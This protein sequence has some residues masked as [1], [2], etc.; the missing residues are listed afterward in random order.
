MM[1]LRIS[2]ISVLLFASLMTSPAG[3]LESGTVFSVLPGA[4]Y[5][6]VYVNLPQDLG[7][8]AV[9]QISE[10]VIESN[11]NS[12]P[13]VDTTYS[14]VVIEPGVQNKNPVCFYYSSKEEGDFSFYSIKLSSLGLG[15]SNSISGG[16]CVSNYSD[17]DM[18]IDASNN[19][20]ICGL[21][22]ENA[23]IVDLSFGEDKTQARPGEV[24]SKTLYITSY[25]NL[26]IRLSIATNLQNDFG[27][28]AVTTSPSKPMTSRTFKIKAPDQEG[29]FSMAVL[30]QVEGCNMQA[31]KKQQQGFISV[32]QSEKEYFS[33]SVI[34]KNINLKEPGDVTFRIVVSNHGDTKDF[35]IQT[36]SDPS[37]VVEP[38]T[39][40]M[41]VEKEEETTTLFKVTPGS[42]KL[43]RLDFKIST[44]TEETT[45]S[46][47]IT[48]GEL[49]TDALRYSEEVEKNAPPSLLEE[50][51]KA[52]ED[53]AEKYNQTSY[54][55]DLK[56]YEEFQKT[57]DEAQMEIDGGEKN[58]TVTPPKP[59][60][61]GG[62]NIMFIAIPLVIVAA[63][64]LIF[65]AFKK[66]KSN[67]SDAGGYQAYGP[68]DERY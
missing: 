36:S 7:L 19:A 32:N 6:C 20:D 63:A 2:L 59:V 31:C 57:L 38:E 37:L 35:A 44:D 4:G 62:F 13:W 47:Y 3:A 66:A 60:D 55:D 29:V 42:E 25:A 39:N 51:T 61:D 11:R 58:T 28:P 48:I 15:V 12:S 16:L 22:N 10:T 64:V 24:V 1:G 9:N 27:E 68:R 53:Y 43:Y 26:K 8:G 17:V 50:I 52:K 33:V 45:T 14:K 21:L 5:K 34:P 41:T 23:D 67:S 40:T 30:A 65:I 46:A 18:G 54:G 49:L 56:D